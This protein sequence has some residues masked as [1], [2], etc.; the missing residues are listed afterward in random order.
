[1]AMF[2][3]GKSDQRPQN[4]GGKSH[5]SLFKQGRIQGLENLDPQDPAPSFGGPT[6][7]IKREITLCMRT[8]IHH[9]LVVNSFQDTL[10]EILSSPLL[11]TLKEW[12]PWRLFQR[13]LSQVTPHITGIHRDSGVVDR[14]TVDRVHS[15]QHRHR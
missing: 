6:N 2:G 4:V 9:I 10:S 11:P 15:Y 14:H 7:F 1:M 5:N 12:V 13:R 8:R 3:L